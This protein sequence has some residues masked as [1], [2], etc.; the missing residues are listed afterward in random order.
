MLA[1]EVEFLTG[2]CV[3]T[4]YYDRTK[5]EW[6]PHP[7]RLFSALVAAHAERSQPGEREALEWLQRQGPPQIAVSGASR[8]ETVT[9]FVPVNDA[10]GVTVVPEKRE[11]QQRTFPSVTPDDPKVVFVW[12]A[13][14]AGANAKLLDGIAARVVRMGHSSSLVAARVIESSPPPTMVPA[15]AGDERL[16]IV[17]PRQLELLERVHAEKK[18]T[19]PR[20]MPALSQPYS[21]E[22]RQATGERAPAG[23]FGDDWLIFE[24]ESGPRLPSVAGPALATTFRKSLLR[25]AEQPPAEIL[26]GHGLEGGPSERPHAAFVPLPFVGHERADGSILGLALVLPRGAS[27]EERRTVYRAVAAWET[28]EGGEPRPVPVTCGRAGIVRFLRLEERSDRT[29]LQPATWCRQA[30]RW[31]TATPIALD[32]NPGDLRGADQKAISEA[33]AVIAKSCQRVGLPAPSKVT[34]LPAAPIPGA[35][36]AKDFAPFPSEPGKTR[37]VLTHA[38]VEF[39]RPI[40]G[41]VLLGAGRYLGLGLLRPADRNG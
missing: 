24:R 37:R 16:R 13:V 12:P 4:V 29:N 27:D 28:G 25:T 14:D 15:E 6:P 40:R 21:R 10:T 22:A 2:R 34:I 26:S 41:P 39:A 23:V 9:V 1:I 33:E 17:H 36:K 11:R 18:E 35:V 19:E 7:A 30:R 5:A 32:E 20:V 8:R 31:L 38:A 3:A